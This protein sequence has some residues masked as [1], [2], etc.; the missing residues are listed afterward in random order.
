MIQFV[1]I[2][3]DEYSAIF[4]HN[5]YW[6]SINR[7][8]Q[9]FCFT[10]KFYIYILL[11]DKI[12]FKVL[13][14]IQS[15]IML[16]RIVRGETYPGIRPNTVAKRYISHL[17]QCTTIKSPHVFCLIMRH[18]IVYHLFRDSARRSARFARPQMCL[19]VP[20]RLG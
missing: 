16:A 5:R 2:N 12:F 15:I 10:D 20:S 6:I 17:I 9:M 1:Y 14:K 3:N 4:H 11:K 18:L 13:F 19:I 7:R 8:K